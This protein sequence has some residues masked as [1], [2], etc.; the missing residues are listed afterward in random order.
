MTI[1]HAAAIMLALMV[2]S[3]MVF[4]QGVVKRRTE[5]LKKDT[6]QVKPNNTVPK[7]ETSTP[8]KSPEVKKNTVTEGTLQFDFGTWIGGIRNGKPDG[9]GKMTYTATHTIDKYSSSIANPED[10]LMGTYDNGQL[11]SGK[12]Y[13]KEGQLLKTIIP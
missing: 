5:P 10:Y 3:G 7:K 1:R 8:K 2:G 6:V 13:N 4:G 11:V 12:L 9:K